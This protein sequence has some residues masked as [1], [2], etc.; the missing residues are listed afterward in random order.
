MFFQ[1]TITASELRENLKEHFEGVQ[2]SNV[3]QIIHRGQPIRVLMTQEHYLNLLGRLAAAIP[4]T[5]RVDTIPNMSAE[6]V[7]AIVLRNAE[8]RESSGFQVKG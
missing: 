2:G 8:E 3:L 1:E 4:L 7:A 5:D 6:E